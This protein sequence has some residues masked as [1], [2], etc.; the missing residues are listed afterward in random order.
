MCRE[1]DKRLRTHQAGFTLLEL[2]VVVAIIALLMGLVLPALAAARNYRWKVLASIEVKAIYAAA[3]HYH[4]QL[5]SYPPDTEDYGTGENP[6][7]APPDP[8]SIVTYLGRAVV[9][10][11]TNVT[12]GPFLQLKPQFVRDDDV[13]LDPWLQPY[14]FDALHTEFDK[15]ANLVRRGEPYP[16]G[17]LDEKKIL[18][19]K[20][21]SSGPD[22]KWSAGSNVELGRG[23]D[24]DDADNITSWAD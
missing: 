11:N 10:K 22:R 21:W 15:D 17:T 5:N 18:E 6:E 20:V 7:T 2:L 4:E 14:H 23:S 19:V 12:Y 16:Q 13:Y 24:I 8:T 3:M 1:P 9:E